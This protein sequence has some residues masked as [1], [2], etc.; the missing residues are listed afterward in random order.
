MTAPDRDELDGLAG[1]YVLG[2]LSADERAAAEA[3][4]AADA[5]FRRLVSDWE[6]RLQPLAD[7]A[8]EA[9]LAVPVVGDDGR[10][11]PVVKA[12]DEDEPDALGRRH[13]GRQQRQRDGG[14]FPAA[15]QW[16]GCGAG[17]GDLLEIAVFHL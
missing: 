14:Q 8:D 17:P 13:Q 16:R 10:G 3:R 9:P 12:I 6:A 1:E 2:T 7:S 4:Y 15:G 5:E 11:S